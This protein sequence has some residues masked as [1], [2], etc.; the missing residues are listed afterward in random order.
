MRG[1]RVR[2]KCGTAKIARRD[3]PSNTH[4][5][6]PSAVSNIQHGGQSDSRSCFSSAILR[7]LL[8]I[9]KNIRYI[10]H[11]KEK[12]DFNNVSKFMEGS[13]WETPWFIKNS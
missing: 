4:P 8:V 5:Q 6:F 10:R 1:K 11:R 13:P 2:H 9:G 12:E 7:L 3:M